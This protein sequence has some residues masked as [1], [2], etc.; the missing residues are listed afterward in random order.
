MHDTPEPELVIRTGGHKR[1]SNFLLF[2]VAYSELYFLDCMWPDLTEADLEKAI[3]HIPIGEECWCMKKVCVLGDGAW[4][5]AVA[6]LLAHNGYQ[7][8]LWC[9]NPENAQQLHACA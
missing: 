1:L 7:V 9:Y 2:H 8:A 4:G 6:T 3:A 5:T